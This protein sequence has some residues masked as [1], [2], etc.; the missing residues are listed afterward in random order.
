MAEM[1]NRKY[2]Q[3]VAPEPVFEDD[4]RDAPPIL[5]HGVRFPS[6][7]HR[8]QQYYPVADVQPLPDRLDWPTDPS[9]PPTVI[10]QQP[11]FAGHAREQVLGT[12]GSGHNSM[13]F[14]SSLKREKR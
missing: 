2:R 4:L 5:S 6:N 12:A 7:A 13:T 14:Q 10:R 11:S 8:E 9:Q 1:K 3:H